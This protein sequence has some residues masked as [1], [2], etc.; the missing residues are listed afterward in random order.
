[1]LINKKV[2]FKLFKNRIEKIEKRNNCMKLWKSIN[3]V[4]YKQIKN[5][6]SKINLNVVNQPEINL[7]LLERLDLY[8]E[9]RK[10]QNV[11]RLL[12]KLLRKIGTLEIIY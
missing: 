3:Y 8:E 11:F 1:M 4:N 5:Y 9:L 10:R 12:G 6:C 2:T 7:F